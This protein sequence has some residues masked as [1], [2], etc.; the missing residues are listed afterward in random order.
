MVHWKLPDKYV[1]VGEQTNGT[2]SL[3]YHIDDSLLYNTAPPDSIGTQCWY[4]NGT[5]GTVSATITY[6]FA[7]G[8]TASIAPQG[9]F[10]IYRPSVSMNQIQEP[11]FFSKD[12]T[13]GLEMVKLGSSG[14]STTGVMAY[15]VQYN[16]TS[17][18]VGEITQTCQLSYVPDL[19]GYNFSDWRC[20]GPENYDRPQNIVP[21]TSSIDMTFNDGPQNQSVTS[22]IEVKGSFIDYIRFS[23]NTPG[24]IYVTLGIVTWNMD[25][26]IT[27]T[28]TPPSW[29][30]VITNTPDPVGPNT[31]DQFPFYTRPR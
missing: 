7:N 31:S 30:F 22:P 14:A 13:L 8:Q 1:N 27:H 10:S 4:V 2:G 9:T 15:T 19:G 25:G 29:T 28:G 6:T 20:D 5:G 23:P 18:G 17:N 21:R 24:S 26:A 11:R 12:N 3:Y 16:T